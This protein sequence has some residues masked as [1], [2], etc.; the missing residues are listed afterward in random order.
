MKVLWRL[1]SL[2]MILYANVYMHC[3]S[4]Q[5]IAHHGD[6]N[7]WGEYNTVEEVI[8][9]AQNRAKVA[10]KTMPDCL[11]GGIGASSPV[12]MRDY[13]S[14]NDREPKNRKAWEM[15][16]MCFADVLS[17]YFCSCYHELPNNVC[18]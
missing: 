5:S 10:S 13:S 17:M 15:I 3:Q 11:G 18:I 14:P 6:N 16:G 4:S 8:A 7:N 1:Y 2:H 12:W 9:A